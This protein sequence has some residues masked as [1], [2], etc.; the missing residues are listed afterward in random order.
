M[1]GVSTLI[2]PFDEDKHLD[3]AL[4]ALQAV[5]RAHTYPPDR[6][7]DETLESLRT[8]LLEEVPLQRWVALIGEEPV[9]FVQITEPHDYIVRHLTAWNY[10]CLADGFAEVGKFFVDPKLQRVGVGAKLLA[11]ACA[12]SWSESRQPVLAVV[13]TFTAAMHLYEEGMRLLGTF[14]GVHGE[15]WVYADEER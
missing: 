11:Q 4:L 15:N 14:N 10:D 8:W 5:K 2:V 6:D 12:F 7:A 9:G 3:Q 1:A 13:T